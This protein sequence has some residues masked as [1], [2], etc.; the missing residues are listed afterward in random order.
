MVE[1]QAGVFLPH[2]VCKSIYLPLIQLPTNE[3]GDSLITDNYFF[4]FYFFKI[5]KKY[6]KFSNCKSL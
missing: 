4:S 5:V 1:R 3:V 2:M 6:A